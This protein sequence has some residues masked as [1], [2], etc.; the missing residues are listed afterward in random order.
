MVGRIHDAPPVL[1]DAPVLG[2][3]YVD[4]RGIVFEIFQAGGISI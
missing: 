2:L 4:F 3:E 1:D